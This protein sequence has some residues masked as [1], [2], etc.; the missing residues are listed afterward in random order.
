VG[1]QS[2]PANDSAPILIY[3]NPLNPTRYV[4]L[5]SGFTFSEVAHLSNAQQTPKLPDFAIVNLNVPD[6]QR[7]RDGV[8]AAGFF[9]ENWALPAK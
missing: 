5:N 9:D 8:L 3:P 1:Q 2:F 7:D 6:A 4:V